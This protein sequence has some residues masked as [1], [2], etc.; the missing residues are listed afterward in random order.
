M[1][2]RLH[3]HGAAHLDAHSLADLR[4]HGFGLEADLVLTGGQELQGKLTVLA[5]GGGAFHP[6]HGLMRRDL[7][8]GDTRARGV[9]H[10]S[11]QRSQGCILGE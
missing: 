8:A 11:A 6:G 5:A 10:R 7:R 4:R 1:K 3:G 2:L 9:R